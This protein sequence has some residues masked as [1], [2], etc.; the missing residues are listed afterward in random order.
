MELDEDVDLEE[1]LEEVETEELDEEE[2]EV[3]A[4]IPLNVAI[5][6]AQATDV[7]VQAVL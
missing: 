2:V 6:A 7:T 1:L 5:A 4:V 3:V